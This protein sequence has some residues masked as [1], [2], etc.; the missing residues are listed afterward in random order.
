[1]TAKVFA[2]RRNHMIRVVRLQLPLIT[3]SFNLDISVDDLHVCWRGYLERWTIHVGIV[4]RS[5]S[6]IL[7]LG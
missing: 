1:M 7:Q 4:C 3:V 5:R 6:E 2:E